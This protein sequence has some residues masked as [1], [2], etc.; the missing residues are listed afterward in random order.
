[1]IAHTWQP[2][3]GL[4]AEHL[5]VDFEE[6]DALQKQWL[7]YRRRREDDDPDA[8]KAFIERVHRRW[9]IET[10]IIE[11][12]YNIDRG[13]TQTLVEKGLTAEFIEFGATDRDPRDLIA[14]LH[15]HRDAA[16]FVTDVIR[17]QM[18]LSKHYVRQLHQ[19]LLR[20]QET[21]F[22]YD[23]FRTRIET[24]LDRGG[25]KSL[26]N[27]PTRTDGLVH[28]Y[29]PA[30]QVDSELDN[31][32]TQYHLYGSSDGRFHPL[33][34]AAWLHHRFTQIHPFQDGN[35]R[36]ARTLLTWHLVREN[37]LP[38]VISRNLKDR[39]IDALESADLGDL[40]PFVDFI[41]R[42]QRGIILEALGEPVITQVPNVFTQVLDDIA[43]RVENRLERDR[44]LL[45][46]VN[47]VA[48]ELRNATKVDLENR[49]AE[50]IHRF[51]EA[52]LAVNATTEWGG[53][54]N[55]R[56]HWYQ[57]QVLQTAREAQHWVNFNEDRFFVKLSI[58]PEDR[59]RAPRLVFVISLHH[60]GRQ[61]TG[62]MAATAFA[63][64][65]G[66]GP[67]TSDGQEEPNTPDFKNCTIDPFTFTAVQDVEGKARRFED[68]VQESLTVALAYWG[69]YLS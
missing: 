54:E 2:I 49:A 35:G 52:D 68:W 5:D 8:Y 65:L 23:Q 18:P 42:L 17:Q 1:M 57:Y 12:I 14:V 39:Y 38:I 9:A 58:N 56:G 24:P 48:L 29:C 60:V 32:I 27:N 50:I 31:L 46:S 40:K 62:I 36:V 6:I 41:V 63:Q 51:R 13:T 15:D 19:I 26:P 53:P 43:E 20:N 47:K 10:G 11:G 55:N 37:Y 21:Y 7:T 66:P 64:V 61:L 30:I 67:G 45:R 3:T 59:T 22:A 34:S 44:A 69:E 4:E 25:F 33:S 16:E 28:E